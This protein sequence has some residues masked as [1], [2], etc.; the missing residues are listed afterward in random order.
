MNSTGM[1]ASQMA[2]SINVAPIGDGGIYPGSLGVDPT[3]AVPG[4]AN[5]GQL[6]YGDPRHGGPIPPGFSGGVGLDGDG[7]YGG[8][9][10][11]G[12]G[13]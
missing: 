13:Y 5:T 9:P 12:A 1:I 2:G 4:M 8:Y 11:E 7:T 10:G 3:Q 6:G